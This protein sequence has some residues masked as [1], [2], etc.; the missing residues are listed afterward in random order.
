ME[1]TSVMATYI[2]DRNNLTDR[3]QTTAERVRLLGTMVPERGQDESKRYE[4]E[5]PGCRD[6]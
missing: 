1:F 2:A 3:K 4:V 5:K 6:D